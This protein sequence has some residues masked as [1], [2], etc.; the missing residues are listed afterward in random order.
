MEKLACIYLKKKQKHIPNRNFW[1]SSNVIFSGVTL[2]L[3]RVTY[4]IC[5]CH[6]AHSITLTETNIAPENAWLELVSFLEGLFSGA[7]PLLVSGRVTFEGNESH[8]LDCVPQIFQ[9]YT[10]FNWDSADL[11]C[12]ACAVT[13]AIHNEQFGRADWQI[14]GRVQSLKGLSEVAKIGGTGHGSFRTLSYKC[15][16]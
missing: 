12:Y 11:I 15:L 2:S 4:W 3:G 5:Y 13:A 9:K 14:A 1:K 10:H 7:K 16:I 6:K 8:R